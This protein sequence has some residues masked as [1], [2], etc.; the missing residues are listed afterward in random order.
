MNEQ[1]NLLEVEPIGVDYVN[2]SQQGILKPITQK[3]EEQLIVESLLPES[4]QVVDFV[5]GPPERMEGESRK[6]Y[7]VRRKLEHEIFK[8]RM[9]NGVNVWDTATKGQ[10]T[11]EK[12]RTKKTLKR[13]G[14][15]KKLYKEVL[16]GL[17]ADG[18][19]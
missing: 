2:V 14:L 11:S 13:M 1:V 17:K 6:H 19:V 3:T 12:T 7:I 4:N 9:K 18:R 16:K 5:Y 8:R 15:A 10:C